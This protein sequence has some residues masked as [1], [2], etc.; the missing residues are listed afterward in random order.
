MVSFG[1]AVR[2]PFE[3]FKKMLIGA[4][5][6]MIPVVN[7]ITG[8]FV[9]GYALDVARGAMMRRFNLPEWTNWGKLFVDGLLAAII[10]LIWFLPAI[11]ISVALL[12]PTLLTLFAGETVAAGAL[13]GAGALSGFIIFF[14]LFLLTSYVVP[15]AVMVY[16]SEGRFGA[17]FDFKL[18]LSKAF[19]GSYFI[20]WMLAFGTTVI[21]NTAFMIIATLLG[22]LG[23]TGVIISWIIQGF[24]LYISLMIIFALYGE[25][26]S[27][28]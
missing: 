8:L 12:G 6:S 20:A 1:E 3:D 23:I 16:V 21:M 27:E 5:L 22:Y 17:G 9:Y 24:I 10:G 7:L 13:V 11:G 19:S 4:A 26:F 25:G 15:A 18:I 14:I 28:A 2:L